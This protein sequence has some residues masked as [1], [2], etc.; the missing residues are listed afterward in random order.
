M[1][2]WL[3]CII[4]SSANSIRNR[5]AISCGDHHCFSHVVT[6]AAS[7]GWLSFGVFGRR[8]CS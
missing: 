1:V 6:W 5:P 4:G 7:R 8:A 3:T 2:S